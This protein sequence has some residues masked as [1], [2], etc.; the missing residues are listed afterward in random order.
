M[1]FWIF[2][3]TNYIE[4]HAPRTWGNDLPFLVLFSLFL[5]RMLEAVVSVHVALAEVEGAEN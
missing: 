3:L 4:E 5:R 2:F 1:P